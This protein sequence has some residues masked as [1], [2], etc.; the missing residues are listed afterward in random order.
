MTCAKRRV[1]CVI[2]TEDGKSFVGENDCSNPQNICPRAPGEDYTK[3]RTICQQ[4]GHAEVNALRA[5]GPEARGAL[6]VLIGHSHYC[7]ACQ[8]ELFRAGVTALTIKGAA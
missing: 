5:A 1:Q 2:V 8:I 7:A 4:T 6:A 3:C